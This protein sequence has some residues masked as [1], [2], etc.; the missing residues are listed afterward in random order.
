MRYFMNC[1]SL[2][3][4]D[5]TMYLDVDSECK[6]VI[7]DD[8]CAASQEDHNKIGDDEIESNRQDIEHLFQEADFPIIEDDSLLLELCG[9][10]V[11]PVPKF[12]TDIE[13]PNE[14]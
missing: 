13:F 5:Y 9:W 1:T 12:N 8:V 2:K 10:N 4:I 7:L 14:S 3:G 6:E 11:Y